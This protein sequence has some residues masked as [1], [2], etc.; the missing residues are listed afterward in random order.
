MKALIKSLLI[1]AK[2]LITFFLKATKNDKITSHEQFYLY[3]KKTF[4]LGFAILFFSVLY[5]CKKTDN[6]LPVPEGLEGVWS[7]R[8]VENSFVKFDRT[9]TL[10][11]DDYAIAFQE[12]QVLVERKNA[13]WCGTPPITYGNFQGS[14]TENDSII[15]ITVDNWSG[16][17][18]YEWKI[19]SI[20]ENH[21][22]ILPLS[23]NYRTT[24]D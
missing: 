17:A 12:N 7:N 20:T 19:I 9:T 6:Q 15:K 11:K 23:E 21:L 24:G 10:P 8:V 18:D 22:Y 2:F 3:M 5:S 1:L 4:Y 13:G 14:W 16:L